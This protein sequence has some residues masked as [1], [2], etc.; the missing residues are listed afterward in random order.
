MDFFPGRRRTNAVWGQRPYKNCNQLKLN[1]NL[2][3]DPFGMAVA[4]RAGDTNVDFPGNLEKKSVQGEDFD[5]EKEEG[6]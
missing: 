5:Q 1:E 2:F 4:F 3:S 6:K